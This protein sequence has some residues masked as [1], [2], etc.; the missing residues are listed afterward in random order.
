VPLCFVSD[1]HATAVAEENTPENVL[2]ITLR[3]RAEDVGDDDDNDNVG[4]DGNRA[5]STSA[6]ADAAEKAGKT[7]SSTISHRKSILVVQPLLALTNR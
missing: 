3:A 4:D 2:T 5:T 1:V 7:S 6:V